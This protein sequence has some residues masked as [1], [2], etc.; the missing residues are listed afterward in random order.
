MRWLTLENVV[1]SPGLLHPY[2]ASDPRTDTAAKIIDT[3]GLE[4]T[5]YPDG[6]SRKDALR[7]SVS[8]LA[9]R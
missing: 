4:R 7:N 2:I 6:T 1:D 9:E 5:A 8:G 3:L